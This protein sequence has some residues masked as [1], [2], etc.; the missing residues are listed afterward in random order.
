MKMW[1]VYVLMIFLTSLTGE[2]ATGSLVVSY[3]TGPDRERLD[4]VRFRLTDSQYIQR[5]FPQGT[6]YVSDELHANRVVVVD[7]L[8]PGMY[9]IEFLIPNLDKL[10]ENVE[11]KTVTIAAGENAKVD[12][13]FRPRYASVRAVVASAKTGLP[14]ASYPM[15]SLRNVFGETVGQSATGELAI[16]KL[17]PGAYTLIFEEQDGYI[18]PEP[19]VFV[20]QPGEPVG[21]FTGIYAPEKQH[22]DQGEKLEN[23]LNCPGKSVACSI[24]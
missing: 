17:L 1:L 15:V 20:A 2:E 23:L 6:N 7:H 13:Y 16:S 19:I 9:T 5:L 12:Q 8:S 3:Q 10:F 22:D 18:T 21:P 11:K 4:R 24:H 14:F